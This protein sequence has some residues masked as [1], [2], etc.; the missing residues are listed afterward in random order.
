MTPTEVKQAAQIIEFLEEEIQLVPFH[1][2][3]GDHIKIVN[4]EICFSVVGYNASESDRKVYLDWEKTRYNLRSIESKL[5]KNFY[6]W[7]VDTRDDEIVIV[8]K[9]H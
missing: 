5:R 8:P 3:K 9:K 2:K 6:S 4:D 7:T 1:I